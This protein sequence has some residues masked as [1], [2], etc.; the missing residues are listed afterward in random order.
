M[1][2]LG[3]ILVEQVY[4]NTPAKTAMGNKIRLSRHRGI[5]AYDFYFYS[6]ALLLRHIN[7]KY[8]PPAE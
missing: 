2:I 3:M 5:F 7:P 1:A 4:R 8:G 6:D